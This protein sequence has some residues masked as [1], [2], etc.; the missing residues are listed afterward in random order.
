MRRRIIIIIIAILAISVPALIALFVIDRSPALQNSVLQLTNQ[1]NDNQNI[2]V[3]NTAVNTA[4]NPDRDP[5][6]YVARNFAETY[7][8][9]TNQNNLAHYEQAKSWATPDFAR[10]LDRLIAQERATPTTPFHRLI[11]TALVVSITRQT[12]TVASVTVA[13]QREETIDTTE[14]TF[15]QELYVDLVKQGADWK[16]N[17]AAWQPL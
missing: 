5:I 3:T 4:V 16:V 9:G 17:A 15:T 2:A 8:S 13:L 14:K 1:G 6:I 12:P 10:F 11:S 7:G